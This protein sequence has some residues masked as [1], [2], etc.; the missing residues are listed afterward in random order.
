MDWGMH[1]VLSA[2]SCGKVAVL[3]G[4]S[5]AERDISLLSG[6]AVLASLLRSGVDAHAVDPAEVDVFEVLK[7]GQFDR[8]MI[9]L[10]GRT[11]EDG[12][13]QGALELLQLPYTGS[14]VLASALA[15]DKVRT[16][17]LWQNMGLSTPAFRV[18]DDNTDWQSVIDELGQVFVKPVKEG[19]SI[20]ISRAGTA[21][22]LQAAYARA[23]EFDSVVIAEEFIDGPSTRLPFW[24]TGPCHL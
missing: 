13:M 9:M 5:S 24:V 7:E 4:G 16:K 11:G 8:V 23:A 20:G 1:E 21:E 3:M 22:E 17:K 10:H 18:L 2:E 19:S 14:G 6:K 15:M 12:K